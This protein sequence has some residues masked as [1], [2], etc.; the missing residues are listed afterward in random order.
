M[1]TV[2]S[3]RSLSLGT[4]LLE[5]RLC[6]NNR[7]SMLMMLNPS[8]IWSGALI[9]RQSYSIVKLLF[10]NDRQLTKGHKGQT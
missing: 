9:G 1:N 5:R 8:G 2:L 10:T 6:R 7:N 3:P 4:F